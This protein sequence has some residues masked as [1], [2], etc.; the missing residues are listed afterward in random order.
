LQVMDREAQRCRN[1]ITQA[2]PAQTVHRARPA[3]TGRKK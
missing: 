3:T 1:I 2:Q